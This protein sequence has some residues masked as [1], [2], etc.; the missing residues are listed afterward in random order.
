MKIFLRSPYLIRNEGR[1]YVC[2]CV[3]V[4]DIS[5]CRHSG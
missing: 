2:V 5:S 3:C 4:C 1:V